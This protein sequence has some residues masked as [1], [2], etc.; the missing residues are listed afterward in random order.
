MGEI[1]TGGHLRHHQARAKG[2]GE[3]PNGGIGNARHRREKD[4]VGD[5]NI[6]YFHGNFIP[7]RDPKFEGR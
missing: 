5:G 2:G 7:K 6:A 4:P 1:V 3:A